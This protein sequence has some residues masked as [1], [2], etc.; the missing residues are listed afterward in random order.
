MDPVGQSHST[1][2][3]VIA[4]NIVQGILPCAGNSIEL[5]GGTNCIAIFGYRGLGSA[6]TTSIATTSPSTGPT[7]SPPSTLASTTSPITAT[8]SYLT[9]TGMPN[10]LDRSPFTGTVNSGYLILCDTAL[11]GYDLT[12]VNGE[13]LADCIAACNS[14]IASSSPQQQPCVAVEYDQVSFD[15]TSGRQTDAN[16]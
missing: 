15:P 10:C 7:S 13:S 14:Y 8:T 11:P 2:L 4:A 16:V 3:H 9:S 6:S 12:Q 1:H 5:C